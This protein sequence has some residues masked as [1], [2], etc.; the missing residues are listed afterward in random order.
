MGNTMQMDT[1]GLSGIASTIAS[2]ASGFANAP[3][4]SS[5]SAFSALSNAGF[6]TSSC[7]SYDAALQ[8]ITSKLAGLAS[9]L[10]GY[11]GDSIGNDKK[12]EEEIPEE[13]EYDEDL[14]SADVQEGTPTK[15]AGT[16]TEDVEMNTDKKEDGSNKSGTS[17]R[18]KDDTKDE[19]EKNL[20]NVNNGDKT[21]E[22]EYTD[23]TKDEKKENLNNINKDDK[24]KE[25]EY[26]DD[27]SDNKNKNLENI[28]KDETIEQ[29]YN[30]QTNNDLE[31]N[32]RTPTSS[33]SGTNSQPT[34]PDTV[35]QKCLQ[36]LTLS[37]LNSVSD[38]L[39][40]NNTGNRITL[41]DV[42]NNNEYLD[43]FKNLIHNDSR[44]SSELR[45]NINNIDNN[46]LRSMLGNMINNSTTDASSKID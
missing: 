36:S 40:I 19:K 10:N 43:R 2:A 25:Q 18:Y 17:G 26:K 44:F 42:L 35:V 34:S 23:Q 16:E 5:V 30:D 45:N 13:E 32:L 8:A 37:D 20:E 31:I 24:T 4:C 9:S 21:K 12:V 38:E 6:D 28:K 14:D 11:L 46:K 27:T 41:Q 1:D 15:A 29:V 33:R 7:A 3:L 22:Q 39:N